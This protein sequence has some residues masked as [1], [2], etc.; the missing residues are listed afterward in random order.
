MSHSDEGFVLNKTLY[1]HRNWTIEYTPDGVFT[2]YHPDDRGVV[3]MTDSLE[4]AR[5]AIDAYEEAAAEEK[6]P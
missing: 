2:W 4:A 5:M 3:G 1:F 6:A